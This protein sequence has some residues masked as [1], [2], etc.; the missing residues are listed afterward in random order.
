MGCFLFQLLLLTSWLFSLGSSHLQRFVKYGFSLHIICCLV[1][2]FMAW[3]VWLHVSFV[4]LNHLLIF[5]ITSLS[6]FLPSIFKCILFSVFWQIYMLFDISNQNVT[7]LFFHLQHI[8]I[9]HIFESNKTKSMFPRVP[10]PQN[11]QVTNFPP[12]L[13]NP[14]QIRYSELFWESWEKKSSNIKMPL[15]PSLLMLTIHTIVS[16]PQVVSLFPHFV[17]VLFQQCGGDVN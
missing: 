9:L 14:P 15:S 17:H 3:I 13:E 7:N 2:F 6:S 4:L 11:N 12:M 5:C 10:P 16:P 8:H 1:P